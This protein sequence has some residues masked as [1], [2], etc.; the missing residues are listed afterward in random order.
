MVG[1]M[2]GTVVY[3][4]V[5]GCI[6]SVNKCYASSNRTSCSGRSC[7]NPEASLQEEGAQQLRLCFAVFSLQG[8]PKSFPGTPSFERN[9]KGG[10]GVPVA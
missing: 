7:S 6:C 3:G 8:C 2:T 10:S 9:D 1:L 4:L 5:V